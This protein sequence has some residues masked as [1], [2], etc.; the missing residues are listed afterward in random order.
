MPRPF[1]RASSARFTAATSV[2]PA[3]PT[4]ISL[5]RLS[6]SKRRCA[7]NTS[8]TAKRPAKRLAGPVLTSS[9][10]RTVSSRAPL[11]EAELG[12]LEEVGGHRDRIGLGEEHQRVVDAGLGRPV[13]V[14]AQLL[15]GEQI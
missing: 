15:I 10:A 5:K 9:E 11:V 12:A 4:S 14:V 8:M 13:L 1:T 3:T 7:A 6:R 2:P